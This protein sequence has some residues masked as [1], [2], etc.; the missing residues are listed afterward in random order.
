[1]SLASLIFSII[2]TIASLFGV[3]V[4]FYTVKTVNNYKETLTNNAKRDNFI[5]QCEKYET[6]LKSNNLDEIPDDIYKKVNNLIDQFIKSKQA[7]CSKLETSIKEK[8]SH[9]KKNKLKS[10]QK[11][12]ESL[13]NYFDKQKQG[14]VNGD[15][16]TIE[17]ALHD[18][19]EDTKNN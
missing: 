12:I 17:R 19:I 1:M 8:K 14:M 6:L 7:N 2:G 9:S 5:M 10:L 11:E 13:N 4:T 3:I 18:I 15:N 16:T